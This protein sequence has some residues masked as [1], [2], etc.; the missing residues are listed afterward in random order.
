MSKRW[1]NCFYPSNL[2]IW[3]W[4]FFLNELVS[5]SIQSIQSTNPWWVEL[6][7]K[8]FCSP[9]GLSGWTHSFVTES[10]P[11]RHFNGFKFSIEFFCVVPQLCLHNI[12]IITNF[13]ILKHIKKIFKVLTQY[14]FNHKYVMITFDLFT[15][16]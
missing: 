11:T 2:N 10:E 4:L 1:Q 15:Y 6:G 7:C 5:Q 9:K 3:K 13:K 8:F 14:I 12:L 16:F